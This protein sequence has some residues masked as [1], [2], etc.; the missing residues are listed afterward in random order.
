MRGPALFICVA[1][2]FARTSRTIVRRLRGENMMGD[3]LHTVSDGLAI[4]ARIDTVRCALYMPASNPRA[5]AKASQL[6]ADLIVFDLEDAVVAEDKEEARN[7]AVSACL[8]D[9]G[10][11]LTAI[12]CNGMASALHGAD[13]MAISASKADFIVVPKVEAASEIDDLALNCHKPIIA[14]IETP[15][16]LY[17]AREIAAHPAVCGLFAGTNDLAH[18]LRIDLATGRAGLSLSLQMMVLAA[19]AAGKSVFDGVNNNLDN[20]AALEAE[21]IEAKSLGFTGQ[22]AIHPRQIAPINAIFAPTAAEIDDAR[23][24]IEAAM[25]GAERFRGRMVEAMHVAAAELLLT[26]AGMV[27]SA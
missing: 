22:T 5:L 25:G 11:R 18:E 4:A 16:G 9:Y 26:R 14:M 1:A 24:L 21:A 19:R 8:L 6:D 10:T 7:A 2:N 23:A 12:R 15:A 17:A 3:G 20:M 27:P 13:L